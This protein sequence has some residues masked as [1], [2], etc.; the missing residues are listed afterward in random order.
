MRA[1]LIP[2][3]ALDNGARCTL[4]PYGRPWSGGLTAL[5]Q[6]FEVRSDPRLRGWRLSPAIALTATSRSTSAP[7]SRG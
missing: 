1:T 6:D 7:R 4:E 2:P 5:A 3:E